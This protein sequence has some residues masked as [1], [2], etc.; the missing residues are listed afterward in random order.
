M[1]RGCRWVWAWEG[2]RQRSPETLRP[3]PAL[4]NTHSNKHTHHTRSH[5]ALNTYAIIPVGPDPWWE[6]PHDRAQR[7]SGA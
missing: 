5:P 3:P 4:T 2:A 6:Q 7:F 1:V